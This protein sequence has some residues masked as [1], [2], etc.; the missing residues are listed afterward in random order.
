MVNRVLG[1]LGYEPRV[2]HRLDMNTT[3]ILAFAKSTKAAARVQRQFMWVHYLYHCNANWMCIV[4][5]MHWNCF[6][7]GAFVLT[8]F[9]REMAGK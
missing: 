9:I 7:K 3:G 8:S 5:Y 2:L 1:Y 6:L 4:C